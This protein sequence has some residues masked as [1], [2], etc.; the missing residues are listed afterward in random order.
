MQVK[1]KKALSN[2]STLHSKSPAPMLRS[3]PGC[4]LL[5]HGI[6]HSS[7]LVEQ[8]ELRRSKAGLLG[9]RKERGVE[10]HS[11]PHPV[12]NRAASPLSR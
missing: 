5:D 6:N 11:L 8:S 9:E 4:L 10:L 7:P 2:S 1:K 12:G 3:G